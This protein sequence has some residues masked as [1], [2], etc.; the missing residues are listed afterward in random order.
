MTFY[1]LLHTIVDIGH[2]FTIASGV[3]VTIVH[4]VYDMIC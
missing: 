2:T 4:G 1:L 3:V